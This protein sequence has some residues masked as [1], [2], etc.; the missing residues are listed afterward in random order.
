MSV[1][2]ADWEKKFTGQCAIVVKE[3]M[4]IIRE[5]SKILYNNIVDRTPVGD[6]SLWNW[7]AHAGYTPGTLKASWTITDNTGEIVIENLQ[8]Y[9]YRVE[10]GY[11]T[12]APSGMMRI[13]V[14]EFGSIL[15]E[16]KRKHK[17]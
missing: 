3:D 17:V 14:K 16:V 6:P 1:N 8:P 5:A 13:S 4:K 11:S 7:P 2:V 9:A 10:T 15:D 12:Q